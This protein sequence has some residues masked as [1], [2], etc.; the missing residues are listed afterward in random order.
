M[1]NYHLKSFLTIL[2]VV[3]ILVFYYIWAE[4]SLDDYNYMN[5]PVPLALY[6]II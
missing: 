6:D 4:K 1:Y 3:A 2:H 5:E